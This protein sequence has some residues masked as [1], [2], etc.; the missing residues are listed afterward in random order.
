MHG[1][2]SWAHSRF[3]RKGAV[4]ACVFLLGCAEEVQEVAR[5]PVR[6]THPP[7]PAVADSYDVYERQDEATRPPP[8]PRQTISLGF[9]GNE[10][11]SN[12]VMRDTPMDYA[13]QQGPGQGQG[14]TWQQYIRDPSW[15]PA[16]R[17]PTYGFYPQNNYPYSD[18]YAPPRVCACAR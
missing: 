3:V 15:P 14:Q 13:Q 4:V 1:G 6:D 8:R 2:A 18:P 10:P 9:V 7:A 5:Y 16:Y 11:L 17:P 12:S